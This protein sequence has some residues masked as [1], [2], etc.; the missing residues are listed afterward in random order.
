MTLGGYCWL[1]G[2]LAQLWE[3]HRMH[4]MNPRRRIPPYLGPCFLIFFVQKFFFEIL[5]YGIA[6]N[7]YVIALMS[8]CATS[9]G[10]GHLRQGFPTYSLKVVS[11]SQE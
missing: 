3:W 7:P 5:S 1:T 11:N 10:A 8:F 6:V 9:T 4:S 2:R